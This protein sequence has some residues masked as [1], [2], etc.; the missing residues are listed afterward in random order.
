MAIDNPGFEA[1]QLTG[2]IAKNN[3]FS[4]SDQ[5]PPPKDIAYI[6]K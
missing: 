1:L 4:S 2:T 5:K 3:P 6:E